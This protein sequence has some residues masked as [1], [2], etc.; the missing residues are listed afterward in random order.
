MLMGVDIE[1][2]SVIIFVR[3]LNMMHYIVQGKSSNTKKEI[4]LAL[5]VYIHKNKCAIT[6]CKVSIR[7]EGPNMVIFFLLKIKAFRSQ[8]TVGLGKGRWL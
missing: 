8:V 3:V 2:I 7:I 4:H 1:G 5:I 6:N